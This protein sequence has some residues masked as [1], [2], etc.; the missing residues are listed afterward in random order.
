MK[1]LSYTLAIVAAAA[2]SLSGLTAATDR[3]DGFRMGRLSQAFDHRV[4]RR[5]N[6]Q[7]ARIDDGI[8]NGEL[9]RREVKRLQKDQ[10]QIARMERR[11]ERDGYYSPKERRI[12]ERAL[13]RSSDRIERAKASGHG[14]YQG[15]RHRHRH[16]YHHPHHSR[17]FAYEDP[18]DIYVASS[19]SSTSITAQTEGFSVSWSNSEQH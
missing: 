16:G 14:R 10:R 2:L 7:W 17:L 13:D 11:F 19:S 15:R 12:M 4:D 1:K 5:Q 18:N 3:G 9:S 6:R 8:E